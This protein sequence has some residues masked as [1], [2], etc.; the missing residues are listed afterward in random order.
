RFVTALA[1]YR[2]YV[3]PARPFTIAA[4]VLHVGRYGRNAEDNRMYPLFIGYSSLVRGYDIGSFSAAECG[5]GNGTTCP[6]F[7]QLIG[8]KIL[9]GNIE[10]R[11]P[12]FGLLHVGAATTAPSQLRRPSSMTPALR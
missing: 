12:P 6:V 3:M 7:D 4:R 5:S 8:S 1:D 2:K 11:F 9:V 10:L